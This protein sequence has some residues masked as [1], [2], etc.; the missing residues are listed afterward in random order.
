MPFYQDP[1]NS[2][3]DSF[4][5]RGAKDKVLMHMPLTTID[6]IAAEL[7]IEHV[8]L[9]KMDIKGATVRA[10]QGAAGTL[11][12]SRSRVVISTEEEQDDPKA[13]AATFDALGMG[14][15]VQCGL[16]AVS[17]D[18]KVHPGVLFFNR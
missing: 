14:Y 2:A 3:A 6:K 7:K 5:V 9:I 13:I 16:C 17:A 8:D 11:K 12:K 10:L 15:R 18:Y 1:D 4:V